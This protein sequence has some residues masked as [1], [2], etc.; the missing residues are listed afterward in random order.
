MSKETSDPVD[1]VMTDKQRRFI[2]EY[3]VDFNATR[4]AKEAGYSE[5]SARQIAS[6]LL[7][8]HDIRKAISE[9]LA[10]FSLSAA[11]VTSLL[12]AQ[13]YGIMPSRV[14][15][16]TR[17]LEDGQETQEVTKTEEFDSQRA[18]NTLARAR[19][20]FK[21]DANEEV[22]FLILRDLKDV[23]PSE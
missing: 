9:R 8:N 14:K 23:V 5:N 12:S 22:E 13:A 17:V 1:S 10:A 2:G 15:L 7:S 11:E 6:Q 21:D 16:V 3:C 4:A 18:L 19:G 20:L